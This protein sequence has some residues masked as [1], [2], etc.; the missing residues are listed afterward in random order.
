VRVKRRAGKAV[1]KPRWI[2]LAA[3]VVVLTVAWMTRSIAI[4]AY[5]ADDYVVI[6]SITNAKKAC[7]ETNDTEACTYASAPGYTRLK[8]KCSE[9]LNDV[10]LARICPVGMIQGRD[11]ETDRAFGARKHP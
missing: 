2:A 8:A 4:D 5:M 6:T 10:I 7:L 9:T 3:A 11:I 1:K